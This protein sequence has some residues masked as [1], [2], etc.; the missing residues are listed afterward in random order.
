MPTTNILGAKG[1]KSFLGH[2]V[3]TVNFSLNFSF[4]HGFERARRDSAESS[5]KMNS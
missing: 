5:I 2:P 1:Q 3:Y 4:H